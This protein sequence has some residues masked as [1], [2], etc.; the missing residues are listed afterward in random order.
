MPSEY[1]DSIS[2]CVEESSEISDNTSTRVAMPS[3]ISDYI[4]TRVEHPSE[5]S[6][7]IN[8]CVGGSSE[9]SDRHNTYVETQ[10]LGAGEV[11]TSYG[12]SV[13]VFPSITTADL[14]S[15]FISELTNLHTATNYHCR[16]IATIALCL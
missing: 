7:A 13:S 2:T 15:N 14:Y 10:G 5:K 11:T 6:E 9:K 3:E 8:T 12:D 1:S 16:F 4:S